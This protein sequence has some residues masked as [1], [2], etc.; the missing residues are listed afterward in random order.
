MRTSKGATTAQTCLARKGKRKETTLISLPSHNQLSCCLIQ[1]EPVEK[2][3]QQAQFMEGSFPE[4]RAEKGRERICRVKRR[5]IGS[6][7]VYKVNI[8]NGLISMNWVISA[9]FSKKTCAFHFVTI[10]FIYFHLPYSG[11]IAI[12]IHCYIFTVSFFKR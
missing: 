2:G 9:S 6:F 10:S 11:L 7:R 3:F 12:W 4:R 5:K 8:Y 1:P